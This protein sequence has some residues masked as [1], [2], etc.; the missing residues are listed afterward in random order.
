MTHANEKNQYIFYQV[1]QTLLKESLL[2]ICFYRDWVVCL[3]EHARGYWNI[4]QSCLSSKSRISGNFFSPYT[5]LT[6]KAW[7]VWYVLATVIGPGGEMLVAF[8]MES[9]I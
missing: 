6:C 3:T 7:V 1:V 9:P 2:A 5:K 8:L 4:W